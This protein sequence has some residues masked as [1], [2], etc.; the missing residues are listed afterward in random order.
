VLLAREYIETAIEVRLA[1]AIAWLTSTIALMVG[2]IGMINTMLTAVFERTRELAIL[3]AIGW[4]K[5]RIV[6][7]ILAESVVL[8][9]A[10][11]VAGTILAV[12]ITQVL[13]RLPAAGRM[14]SGEISPQVILQGFAIATLV[15]L[16]GGLFPAF[17]AARL[18]PTEGLR[19]E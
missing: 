18:V 5:S 14:V 7:L 19:H 10:G 1:R 2:T 8:G 4:R 11:A 6:K 3:R 16:V 17:R 12:V 9:L 15:G 13:S